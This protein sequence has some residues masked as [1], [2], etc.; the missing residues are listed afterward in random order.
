M[1]ISVSGQQGMKHGSGTCLCNNK[2]ANTL[3]TPTDCCSCS[4]SKDCWA[5]VK[6]LSPEELQERQLQVQNL[7]EETLSNTKHNSR[8]KTETHSK[9]TAPLQPGPYDHHGQGNV[10][11]DHHQGLKTKIVD[12]L[13]KTQT[14]EKLHLQYQKQKKSVHQKFE[15]CQRYLT[16]YF[17][18]A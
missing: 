16:A 14:K 17:V 8:T 18:E 12:V 2:K 5:D 13:K 1:K 4:P 7:D 3:M 6:V 15:H 9:Y 11:P 10:G